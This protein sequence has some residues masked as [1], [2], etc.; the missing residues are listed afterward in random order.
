VWSSD[1]LSQ[2]ILSTPAA[3]AI[4]VSLKLSGVTSKR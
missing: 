2:A 3:F 4:P 1:P